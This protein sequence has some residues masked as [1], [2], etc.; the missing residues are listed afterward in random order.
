MQFLCRDTINNGNCEGN[1]SPGKQENTT[2]EM[3]D[4]AD[5]HIQLLVHIGQLPLTETVAASISQTWGLGP[6]RRAATDSNNPEN[7]GILC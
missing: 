6:G 4:E 3:I 2:V 1:Q 7:R 5:Y